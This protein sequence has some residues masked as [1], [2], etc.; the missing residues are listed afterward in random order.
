MKTMHA[1]ESSQQPHVP[2]ES[3]ALCGDK[4]AFSWAGELGLPVV[5][6]Q[7]VRLGAFLLLGGGLVIW[8]SPPVAL[9]VGALFALCLGNPLP[10]H[11]HKVAKYLLQACVVMLGF[12]TNL[13]AVLRAGL[14]GSLFA[15]CTIG[16]TLL[17]GYWLGRVLNI[18]RNTSA[19]IS[20]GTAICGGSAIAAMGCVLAV[21]EGEIAVAIGTVFLLN[22]VALYIFP[23]AGHAL[24][25]N[26]HQFGVWAGV[27]IHDI[28]SVVGASAAY[29]RGALETA[30]AVK[31][32][33][34]LWIVPLTLAIAFTLGQRKR[35]NEGAGAK[36]A[37]E[38]S[39]KGGMLDVE[40]P[41]FIGLFLLASVARSYVPTLAE[42]SPRI[43]LVA[44]GG[45][46]L[47]L[48]LIGASLSARTLRAV[49]WKAALQGLVLWGFISI[50]SLIVVLCGHFGD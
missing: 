32:S 9:I 30:T 47:V 15:A 19:L 26:A 50:A 20:A 18:D 17:L 6:A 13:P 28:S 8:A 23:L 39:R 21:T 36:V 37:V 35:R 10:T 42:W 38:P 7:A 24:H 40:L 46:T 11:G 5:S 45:F 33:R 31:L 12:G 29:G 27:A 2:V 44:R 22:A 14:N 4:Q 1:G 48:C 43:S 3:A 34:S 49:N 16:S 41:W 25:L